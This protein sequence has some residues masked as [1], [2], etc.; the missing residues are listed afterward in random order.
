MGELC[1]LQLITLSCP[2]DIQNIESDREKHAKMKDEYKDAFEGLGWLPAVH[3]IYVD[4][5]TSPVVHP[6]RTVPFPLHV[7]H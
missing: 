5:N 3:Q 6:R 7:E 1:K 4:E 2:V